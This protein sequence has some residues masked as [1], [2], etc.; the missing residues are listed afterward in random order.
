MLIFGIIG[1]LFKKFDFEPAPLV[2]AFILGS[3]MENA[4][5]QSLIISG[6]SLT[7]FLTRPISAV[8]MVCGMLIL[9]SALIPFLRKIKEKVEG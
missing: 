7:I 2:M 8:A 9:I 3:I 1:Y 6:G 5:R 4:F